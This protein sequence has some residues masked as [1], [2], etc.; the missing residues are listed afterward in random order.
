MLKFAQQNPEM[1]KNIM[2]NSG[3][4]GGGQDN[5]KMM[6]S[7]ETILWLLGFPQRVKSFFGS[8]Q[9]K[10][11]IVFVIILIIAYYYR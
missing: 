7:M 11:F 5:Q 9:G 10:L 3:M 6:Q 1:L 4:F 8:T 2:G